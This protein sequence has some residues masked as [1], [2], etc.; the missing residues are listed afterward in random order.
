MSKYY[1]RN[2]PPSAR[3]LA[4]LTMTDEDLLKAERLKALRLVLQMTTQRWLD[5]REWLGALA[6]LQRLVAA[7]PTTV[8]LVLDDDEPGDRLDETTVTQ[9][10]TDKTPE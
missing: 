3:K 1:R 2:K 8:R 4:S 9:E 10:T 5:D 6:R 7:T